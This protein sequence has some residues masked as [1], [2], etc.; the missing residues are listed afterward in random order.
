[1]ERACPIPS[2]AVSTPSFPFNNQ[3]V[4]CWEIPTWLV[5]RACPIC[6]EKVHAWNHTLIFII[7]FH[8][9]AG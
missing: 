7:F 4:I 8:I 2:E 1:V 9:R 5:E 6:F 3:A